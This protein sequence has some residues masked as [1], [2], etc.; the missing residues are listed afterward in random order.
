[1]DFFEKKKI[2]PHFISIFA[3]RFKN[4]ED[5]HI[6]GPEYAKYPDYNGIMLMTV[7]ENIALWILPYYSRMSG[8][9]CNF[10]FYSDLKGNLLFDG[11]FFDYATPFSGGT[12]VVKDTSGK[13]YIINLNS[14]E[15]VLFPSEFGWK[16]FTNLRNNSF[17]LCDRNSGKWGAYSIDYTDYL[18]QPD[19]P[20]IWDYLSFSRTPGLV[21]V[22]KD[23]FYKYYPN[24]EAGP[25]D[26]LIPERYDSVKIPTYKV[27]RLTKEEAQNS[28]AFTEL[29]K[30]I[31]DYY[32]ALGNRTHFISPDQSNVGDEYFHEKPSNSGL[33]VE[34]S[35]IE[36]YPTVLSRLK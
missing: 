8:K 18:W 27:A 2:I 1:M 26:H 12:A 23:D 6:R 5:Y 10:Y 36:D 4:N 15:R 31:D 33:I 14:K 21:Y 3:E 19:I 20:F 13:W 7:D 30:H 17:A 16:D 34:T 22:G 35:S 25:Y 11:A 29:E 32:W 9:K 24:W 28:N